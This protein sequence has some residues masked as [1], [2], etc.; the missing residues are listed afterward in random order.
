MTV[1]ADSTTECPIPMYTPCDYTQNKR[2]LVYYMSPTGT[3]QGNMDAPLPITGIPCDIQ[4]GPGGYLPWG[5][6]TCATCEPGTYSIGG[7]LRYA[8][9][10][11]SDIHNHCVCCC[12]A[13]LPFRF[14]GDASSNVV[15]RSSWPEGFNTKCVVASAPSRPC[16]P[17]VM[18]DVASWLMRADGR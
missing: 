2:S 15:C 7:G 3:C 11:D 10:Y 17:Y 12:L 14:A 1:A 18:C 9:W 5:Q 16:N 8:G 4:C 13:S 6:V